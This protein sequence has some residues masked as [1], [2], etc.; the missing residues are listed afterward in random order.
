M[1]ATLRAIHRLLTTALPPQ[2]ALRL[3]SPSAVLHHQEPLDLIGLS[4]GSVALPIQ[5]SQLLGVL[6][7]VAQIPAQ[8][9]RCFPVVRLVVAR[10]VV[11]WRASEGR[12]AVAEQ[13]SELVGKSASLLL[14]LLA[15]GLPRWFAPC[16]DAG[17]LR[18]LPARDAGALMCMAWDCVLVQATDG[19]NTE[20]FAT[21]VEALLLRSIDK[22]GV[23]MAKFW[24][25]RQQQQTDRA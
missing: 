14:L 23:H 18:S 24:A 1:Q 6:E 5:L 15:A 20:R 22:V 8:F 11:D 10:L 19:G 16:S 7:V 21:L 12:H 13:P 17:C 4:S 3:A 25:L 9:V 2:R